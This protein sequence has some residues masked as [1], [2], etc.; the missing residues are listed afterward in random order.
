MFC[1]T[2]NMQ[3]C[4]LMVLICHEFTA[5][6]MLKTVNI[7]KYKG[8]FL[9]IWWVFAWLR[10]NHA[11]KRKV[12]KMGHKKDHVNKGTSMG[13]DYCCR[14]TIM[15]WIRERVFRRWSDKEIPGLYV[16]HMFIPFDW[17]EEDLKINLQEKSLRIIR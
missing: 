17:W 3:H 16:D 11:R 6:Y 1:M 12:L 10:D 15:A 9:W 14:N 5:L 8:M 2:E 13:F 7:Y 4:K